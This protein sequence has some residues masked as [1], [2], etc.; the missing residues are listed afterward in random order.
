MVDSGESSHAPKVQDAWNDGP[1]SPVLETLHLQFKAVV[2][3]G[4]SI[5]FS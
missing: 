3:T 5:F 1:G 4:P 2:H